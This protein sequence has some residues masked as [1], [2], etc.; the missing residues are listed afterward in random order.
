MLEHLQRRLYSP[1]P[2]FPAVLV[3]LVGYGYEALAATVDELAVFA[4]SLDPATVKRDMF[5]C[6]VWIEI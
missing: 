4:G 5:R 6:F 1:H 3:C 2:L